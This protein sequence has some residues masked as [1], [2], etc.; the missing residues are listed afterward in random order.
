MNPLM[1]GDLVRRHTDD[2]QDEAVKRRMATQCRPRRTHPLWTWA[3][4]IARRQVSQAARGPMADSGP[5]PN[6]GSR[7][8][9]PAQ[10]D[11]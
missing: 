9:S 3:R 2:L 6:S 5:S 11:A 4:R 7:S 10:A 1:Y 8:P